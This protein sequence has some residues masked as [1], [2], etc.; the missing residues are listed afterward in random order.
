MFT[1][2]GQQSLPISGLEKRC[3]ELARGLGVDMQAVE[4]AVCNWQKG[5]SRPASAGAFSSSQGQ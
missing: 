5:G 3:S 1:G 2:R 4:D